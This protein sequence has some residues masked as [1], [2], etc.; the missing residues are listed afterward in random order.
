[1]ITHHLARPLRYVA[2][3]VLTLAAACSTTPRQ[4]PT[5]AATAPGPA[6]DSIVFRAASTG[7]WSPCEGLPGCTV[8]PVRGDAKTGPSEALFTLTAGTEFGKHW[9]TSPEH[10]VGV[11]G[12]IE[13]N[14]EGSG[15]HQVGAGDYLYYPGHAVHWGKCASTTDCVYYVLDDQPYD[16]HQGE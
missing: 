16:I 2:L 13:W 4:A 14:V 15:A 8:L 3:T 1:M 7:P 9:H 6:A 5:T 11:S 12:T 10:V